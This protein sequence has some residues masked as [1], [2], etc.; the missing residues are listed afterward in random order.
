MPALRTPG[1]STRGCPDC[2]VDGDCNRIPAWRIAI[3]LGILAL[4]E[5]PADGALYWLAAV[6]VVAAIALAVVFVGG[7]IAQWWSRSD[8]AMRALHEAQME[9]SAPTPIRVDAADQRVA[10]NER[11]AEDDAVRD[12]AAAEG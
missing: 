6:A 4:R 1:P 10:V 7:Q 11:E 8:P 2:P 5:T 9:P 3:P 12:R